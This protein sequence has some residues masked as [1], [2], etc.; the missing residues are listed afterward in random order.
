MWACPAETETFIC[1]AAVHS[2]SSQLPCKDGR[3]PQA[4]VIWCYPVYLLQGDHLVPLKSGN[5][6][7]CQSA[8]S[9]GREQHEEGRVKAGR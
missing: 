2:G 6:K 5:I 1:F 4:A 7:S 8:H 3:S 9:Q